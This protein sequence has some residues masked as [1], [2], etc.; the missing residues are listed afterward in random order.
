M[1]CN[2]QLKTLPGMG[3]GLNRFYVATTLV[4]SSLVVYTRHLFSPREGFLTHQCNISE[5]IE[6]KRI[7]RWNN[8]ED[9]T[10]KN[11][12]NAEAKK[13]SWTPEGPIRARASDTNR[14]I[15]MSLGRNRHR[16]WPTLNKFQNI[17]ITWKQKKTFFFHVIRTRVYSVL[18]YK[19]GRIFGMSDLLEKKSRP[20]L[21][22]IQ[23]NFNGS[24]T[25][26]T[27]E[28]CSSHG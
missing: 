28:K 27:M 11:N 25:F 8:D 1:S 22:D 12:W 3:L 15:K 19:P 7:Q 17:T 9:P 6:I 26:G 2:F 5:N 21:I 16:V 13:K 10:A 20:L 18:F 4:L 24:N 23:S 14:L